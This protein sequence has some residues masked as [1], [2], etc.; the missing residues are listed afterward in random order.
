MDLSVVIPLHNEEGNVE[1][2]LATL[3]ESL[4]RDSLVGRFEVVCVNDGSNDGTAA[5]LER[6]RA[7]WVTVITLPTRRGQSTA[8]SYGLDAARYDVLAR[9]DGDLQT[10]PE[11]FERLLPLLEQGFDCVHGIR[12]KRHDS[13]VRRWSSLIANAVRRAV[14]RDGFQDIACPLTVFRRACLER[15]PRFEPFHRYLPFLISMQGFAVTQVPVRHFP[16][17]AGR[18]KYG[19]ANRLAIGLTSLF[20]IRWL[21][22]HVVARRPAA[23]GHS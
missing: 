20:V 1:R 16:R 22:R 10:T 7:D 3:G 4:E 5:Q 23:G 15:V 2:L 9:M 13:M 6:H 17:L 12:V 14:L 21:S 18:A 11:D 8:L 19:I